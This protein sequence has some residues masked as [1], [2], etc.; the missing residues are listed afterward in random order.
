MKKAFLLATALFI[1]ATLLFSQSD[2]KQTIQN[3]L[4]EKLR[5]NHPE[6]Q[7]N[8]NL[9]EK[10][11]N[12]S[13]IE[14]KIT[15]STD[16]LIE[17]GEPFI[18]INPTDSNN[19]VLSYME[20]GGQSGLVFPVYFTLDGGQSWDLSSI[21]TDAI[22]ESDSINMIIGGGG[23]PI[24]A[25]DSN[26][27]LYFSWIYLGVNITT[28][29]AMFMVYWAWS[30]DM[31]ATFQ[32]EGGEN[33]LIAKGDINLISGD[34]GIIGDGIFDRPWFDVDRSGGPFDGS[35]YCSGM[36]VPNGVTPLA[37]SGMICK[38]KRAN[39]TT[40]TYFNSPVSPNQN[41]QF[42]NVKVDKL[43]NVH[44]TYGDLDNNKIMHSMSSD[45][46]I[47]FST[48][49]PIATLSY[50][51]NSTNFAVHNRENPVPSLAID[52]TNNSLHV[53]WTSFEN[54]KA[55]GYYSY[56]TNMGTSWS[57]PINIS[58][59]F[60]DT[61]DQV[62]M[63]TVA[64]NEMGYITISGHCL[65]EIDAGTFFTV[66]ST[67]GGQSFDE[68]FLVAEDSTFFQDYPISTNPLVPS[69]FFGDYEASDSYGCKTFS[70]WT[71]GR[72]NQGPKVYIAITNHCLPTIGM[73]ELVPVTDKI[74][75][76][77]LYPNPA[78]TLVNLDVELKQESRLSIDLMGTDG[79]L[80]SSFGEK[81][82]GLGEHSLRFDLPGNIPAGQYFLLIK[83]KEGRFVKPFI[84]E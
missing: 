11:I 25:F 32:V 33:H 36:F 64:V 69:A 57:T 66:Q 28:Y 54:V 56:S 74:K 15:N 68:P 31:G 62:L 65:N 80:I 58:N 48:P 73:P 46:G 71:D 35:L 30:D 38:Y 79:S 82:L 27:K 39:D 21:S 5:I 4:K 63:P 81:K 10:S 53:V 7:N 23:D 51:E 70:I 75:I 34:F 42:G 37:G 83:T 44:I 49:T 72:N 24:F 12:E 1:Q 17:E 45:G 3:I 6:M 14:Q 77:N 47:T 18:L 52:K 13:G 55:K 26:G 22:Y 43:G 29:D 41:V 60:S 8:A 84:K 76:S 50:D 9:Q 59:L 40:F 16:S 78:N 61:V 67:D 2:N 20:F 19:I